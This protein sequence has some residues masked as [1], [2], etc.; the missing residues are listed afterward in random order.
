MSIQSLNEILPKQLKGETP[1]SQE[2]VREW[3]RLY[4]YFSLPLMLYC[5]DNNEKDNTSMALSMIYA[6]NLEEWGAQLGVSSDYSHFYPDTATHTETTDDAIDLFLHTYG[7]NDADTSEIETLLS[8]ESET[9][10]DNNTASGSPL[11]TIPAYDYMS[12]LEAMPDADDAQPWEEGELL[13]KFL[14]ADAAGEQM[15]S[16]PEFSQP[17]PVNT[18]HSTDYH[19]SEA[20]F[21]ESLAKIYIQQRRYTKALEI[22]RK[23]SLNNPEKNVYFADQIRF[24]EKL[25]INV[26]N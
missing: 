7:G 19:E 21:S 22:I 11:I 5:R 16:K 8:Q 1:I 18:E 26:K 10:D 3:Q 20:L 13:D 17:P 24:L 25:I 15:F 9:L 6:A 4:P 2:Q 12:E 23:L 14:R